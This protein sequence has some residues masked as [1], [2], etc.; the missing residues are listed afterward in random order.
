[1]A[2]ATKIEK[3]RKESC[4]QFGV[5]AVQR[6]WGG[7]QIATS[8]QQLLYTTMRLN[9]EREKWRDREERERDR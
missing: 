5:K 3:E 4:C 6:A 8:M 1:M 2:V 7:H 9:R